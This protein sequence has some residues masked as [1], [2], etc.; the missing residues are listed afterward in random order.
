MTYITNNMQCIVETSL[1]MFYSVAEIAS[2][3]IKIQKEKGNRP[4]APNY[5][6]LGLRNKA[7]VLNKRVQ[8]TVYV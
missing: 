6:K 2:Y 5:T 4:S 3:A 7:Q 1:R 8:C